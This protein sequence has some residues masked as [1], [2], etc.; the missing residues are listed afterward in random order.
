MDMAAKRRRTGGGSTLS[1]QVE[2]ILA[3]T[4][5]YALDP[6]DTTT[7]FE[8][9]AETLPANVTSDPVRRIKSKWG[10]TVYNFDAPSD[11]ARPAWDGVGGLSFDGSD[12][13]LS[14]ASTALAQ[15]KPAIFVSTK[16]R[17]NAFT[18]GPYVMQYSTNVGADQRY[19]ISMAVTGQWFLGGRTLD[20]TPSSTFLG[21]TTLSTATN[22]VLS[23]EIDFAGTSAMRGWKDGSLEINGTIGGVP[24]NTSDTASVTANLGAY[25]AGTLLLS[26]KIGRE[27]MCPFIPTA[28]QRAIIEAWINEATL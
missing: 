7:M 15:N 18:G 8:D 11:A 16:V 12:D 26:G 20:A 27:V 24:S 28:P 23:T 14:L 3:G 5:G 21:G 2:V 9:I 22:Y 4:T 13:R 19:S 17:F 1:A 10:T 25:N 6:T